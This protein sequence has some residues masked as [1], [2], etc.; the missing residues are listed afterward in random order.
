VGGFDH[1]LLKGVIPTWENGA[2]V[3]P[4]NGAIP[5]SLF[6]V[7]QMMFFI[8]TPCPDLWGVCRTNEIQLDGRLLNPL[9]NFRVLPDCPL[10]LVG[11]GLVV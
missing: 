6:M 11:H 7:F 8:I 3:V 4:N 9:G 1:I 5:T 2:V 10:G